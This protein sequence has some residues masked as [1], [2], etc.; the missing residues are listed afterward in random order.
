MINESVKQQDSNVNLNY[1]WEEMHKQ[2]EL[3]GRLLEQSVQFHKS[4]KLFAEKMNQATDAFESLTENEVLSTEKGY[5]IIEQHQ[6]VKK[7][8]PKQI[9]CDLKIILLKLITFTFQRNIRILV[10]N[11]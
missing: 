4:A 2:M 9:A 3:R 7:G 6:K 10:K 1:L 5:E 11:I 8:K